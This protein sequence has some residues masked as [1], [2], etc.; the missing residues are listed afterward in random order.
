MNKKITTNFNASEPQTTKSHCV[1]MIKEV[2]QMLQTLSGRSKTSK[3][4]NKPSGLLPK[5]FENAV[6]VLAHRLKERKHPNLIIGIRPAPSGF[7]N[8]GP[9]SYNISKSTTPRLCGNSHYCPNSSRSLRSRVGSDFI[10]KNKLLIKRE[11]SLSHHNDKV[12]ETLK[13]K[14]E[15]SLNLKKKSREQFKEKSQKMHL[16]KS[17]KIDKHI[18][19]G[20]CHLA[21]IISICT[22]IKWKIKNK[23]VKKN[24]IVHERSRYLLKWVCVVSL[25]IGK[26]KKNLK[27]IRK[28]KAYKV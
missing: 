19:P 22:I 18:I 8:L 10:K 20:L 9:G 6:D 5:N 15:V 26:L 28:K 14:I 21:G 1:S 2:D 23:K 16:K 25:A 4:L 24:Q 13:T 3:S 17:F 11:Y 7:D 27:K 12:T